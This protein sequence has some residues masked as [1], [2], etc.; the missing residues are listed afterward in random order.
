MKTTSLLWPVA[1][2]HDAVEHTCRLP[3]V[4]PSPSLVSTACVPVRVD[5]SFRTKPYCVPAVSVGGVTKVKVMKPPEALDVPAIVDD[6]S[7]AGAVMRMLPALVV[8]ASRVRLGLAPEQLAQKTLTSI[9]F[10]APVTPAVKVWAAKEVLLK[11]T[12]LVV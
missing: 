6:A 10:N 7:R 3:P 8:L 4:R 12:P 1:F 2:E 9:F 5:A 11:P